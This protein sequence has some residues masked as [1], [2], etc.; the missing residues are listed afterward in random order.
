MKASN[1][2]LLPQSSELKVVLLIFAF[3]II[4]GTLWYTHSIVRDLEANQ[5]HIASLFAKSFEY[6]GSN[7]TQTD[8]KSVV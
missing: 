6:I 3:I 1:R 8:R 4:A 2:N 7:K 5:K